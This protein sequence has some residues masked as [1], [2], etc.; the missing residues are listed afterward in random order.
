MS[1][2]YKILIN[3][4]SQ[5]LTIN[6][7]GS[8]VYRGQADSNWDLSSSLQR[9]IQVYN[10]AMKKHYFY[11]KWM[12][13]DF[14]KK[15][16]LHTF[17]FKLP[18]NNFE[19]LSIMQ[20][21]GAPTRLLDFTYSFFIATYFALID[22][23]TDSSVWAINRHNLG[24]QIKRIFELPYETGFALKDVINQHHIDLAN[25]LLASE[26]PLKTAVIPLESE[27]FTDRLLKQQGLFLMP[28]D[29]RL[30]FMEN[31]FSIFE[32]P[33]NQKAEQISIEKINQLLDRKV[34]FN[35]INSL[36]LDDYIKELEIN[37][38]VDII[39]FEI[40][41]LSRRPIIEQLYKMNITSEILFPGIDG[42]AK[43][44]IHPYS[45]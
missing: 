1:K 39:K 9:F 15:I 27:I 13:N 28:S 17:N 32:I 40:P 10:P 20:H 23:S 43:S 4:I 5:F 36:N 3:D 7:L 14:K 8:F 11:E 2:Y 45:A 44:L 31:L 24:N 6:N 12:L 16:H 21:Y 19:W 35:K 22:T 42:L 38:P 26:I 33:N 29:D 18:N 25:K 41:K 34:N 30:T 37:S